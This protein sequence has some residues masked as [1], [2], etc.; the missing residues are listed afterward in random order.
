MT[1]NGKGRWQAAPSK[2]HARNSGRHAKGRSL[3]EAINAKCRDCIHDEA[4]PG[5]WREQVA[6]C[7]V[8]RCALW[9]VRPA[10]ES[11]PFADPPRDPARVTR[12]W[13]RMPLG[14]AKS[15]HPLAVTGKFRGNP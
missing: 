1:T 5:T 13:L 11:G 15:G 12:A 8:P 2:A 3:R 6:Q 7:S 4:A 10:P 9:A 14:S